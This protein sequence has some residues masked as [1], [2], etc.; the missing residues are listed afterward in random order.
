LPDKTE[1]AGIQGGEGQREDV[2]Q[3]WAPPYL[4]FGCSKVDNQILSEVVLHFEVPS[5]L[6]L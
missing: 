2:I 1:G 4:G 3:S 6:S 5:L